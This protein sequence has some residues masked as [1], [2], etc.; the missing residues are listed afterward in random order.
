MHQILT[1]CL[2]VAIDLQDKYCENLGNRYIIVT[3]D[4][5]KY[6]CLMDFHGNEIIPENEYNSFF[7]IE[8]LENDF[9]KVIFHKSKYR[10]DS[11]IGIIDKRGKN[12]YKKYGCEDI[13]LIGN[14]YLLVKEFL[15][16]S[17]DGSGYDVYNV[18]NFQ[19][20]ELFEHPL[21]E[22]RLL[23]DGN[24]SIRGDE[25]W[26]ISNGKG[27]IIVAPRYENELKFENGFADISIAGKASKINSYGNILV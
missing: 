11:H 27:K 18:V 20:K 1:P 9:L 24:F 25:G 23:E 15:I 3:K 6:C 17:M 26:G 22:I 14:G 8:I 2:K 4:F 21:K 19:G 10:G 7:K 5:Y 12:I 16:T 13:S